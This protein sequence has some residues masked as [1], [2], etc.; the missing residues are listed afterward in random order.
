MAFLSRELGLRNSEN[1][2]SC[3][4]EA[5][6]GILCFGHPYLKKNILTLEGPKMIYWTHFWVERTALS[7]K[8]VGSVYFGL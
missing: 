8:E 7:Y 6:P 5:M 2:Y 1:W 4:C 3:S